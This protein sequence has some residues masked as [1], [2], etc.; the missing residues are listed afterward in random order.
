MRFDIGAVL[1]G[2]HRCVAGV[3]RLDESDE[4]DPCIEKP[5][6][7]DAAAIIGFSSGRKESF[8]HK[9]VGAVELDHQITR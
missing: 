5:C 2:I 1:L 6:S 7:E 8:V 4:S 9:P 3:R